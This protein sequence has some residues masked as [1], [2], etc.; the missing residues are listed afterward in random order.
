MCRGGV[1]GFWRMNCF[2][3]CVQFH[4]MVTYVRSPSG[5][6]NLSESM[7]ACR[8]IYLVHQSVSITYSLGIAGVVHWR[9]ERIKLCC[10]HFVLLKLLHVACCAGGVV[11]W[12]GED[13]WGLII[14]TDVLMLQCWMGIL[15]LEKTLLLVG[16][17]LITFIA[18]L[19]SLGRLRYFEL[20]KT[21][22]LAAGA[23][24]ITRSTNYKQ[25]IYWR[26][27]HLFQVRWKGGGRH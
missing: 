8:L 17:A 12:P 25:R 20:V 14:A 1:C 9:P 3:R 7:A 6:A 16:V 15:S 26:L 27:H 10:W 11:V 5:A 4:M 24:W 2:A 23:V 21:V 19:E 18:V 22:A 13:G